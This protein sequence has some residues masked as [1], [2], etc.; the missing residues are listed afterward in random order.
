MTSPAAPVPTVT[1]NDGTLIPQL[2]FGVFKVDPDETERIVADALEA[3]YRHIDTAAIYGN[4]EGVGRAIASS[5]LPREE[6]FVTTKLWNGDQGKQSAAAA[7]D[8]SLEKLGLD[9]VDLY[10]IHWPS[11]AQDRYVESW[12]TLESLR[13]AGRTRA[14]G[15]SNF[16]VPHLERL[17]AETEIVP[18]V[19]QIE[20]HPYH[21]QPEVTAYGLQHGIATEAWGPLGQGKYPLLELAE[22]T[23][24]AAAHGATPAQ[25]VLRWH[26]DQGH[27]VFPKSNNPE[28]V[29][30]NF[31]VFGFELT[32]AERDAITALERAGRVGGD[33]NEV[34]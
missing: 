19:N 4:E 22:V 25:V 7:L 10:L 27:I 33:P 12:T 13:A 3:G 29:R 34:Q 23:G 2:G 6:L 21:Q 1:L 9:A 5:G 26:L 32:D 18:A 14:I 16:L 24:P 11:P 15:V 30:E 28:R 31:D 8:A 20:L 17:L